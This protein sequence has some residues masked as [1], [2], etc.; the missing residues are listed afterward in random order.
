MAVLRD[1]PVCTECGREIGAVFSEQTPNN[2]FVGDTFIRWDFEGHVCK[3][4][5]K[6]KVL[7]RIERH[8]SDGS[9]ESIQNEDLQN[10]VANIG[11]ADSFAVSRSY[12]KYLPVNW[13]KP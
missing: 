8:Y 5:E 9:I 2:L 10:Y 7:I 12:I 3:K 1:A 11:I 4:R 13:E 6:E